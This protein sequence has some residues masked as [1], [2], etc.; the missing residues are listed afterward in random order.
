MPLHST[1]VGFARVIE[2]IFNFVTLCNISRLGEEG[3]SNLIQRLTIASTAMENV[4]YVIHNHGGNWAD[5]SCTAGEQLM[6]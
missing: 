4:L 2:L 5:R 3:T 1:V 6:A